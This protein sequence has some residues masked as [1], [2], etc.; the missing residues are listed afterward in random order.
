MKECMDCGKDIPK[1]RLRA[2]PKAGCCV[3]CQE[4]REKAGKFSRHRIDVNPIIESWECVGIT[5]TLVR[6]G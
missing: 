1:E 5:Q 6:G 3:A 4:E 2:N